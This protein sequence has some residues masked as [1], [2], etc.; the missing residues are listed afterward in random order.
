MGQDRGAEVIEMFREIYERTGCALVFVGTEVWEDR[1][2]GDMLSKWRKVLS[3]TVQ[4]G[5]N[6]Q[7]PSELPEEDIAAVWRAFGL[8]DPGEDKVGRASMEV[9]REVLQTCSFGRYVKR[10][11]AVATAAARKGEAYAWGHFLGTHRF[12]QEL[13]GAA[14]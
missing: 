7:L 10:M 12:L 13:A 3:Q 9:I 1:L 5:I 8:P 14:K 4:R 11:R 6:I 2:A